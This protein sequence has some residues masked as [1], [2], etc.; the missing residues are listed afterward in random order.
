MRPRSHEWTHVRS[1]LVGK[2]PFG[3]LCSS[4][5]VERALN[6]L[7]CTHSRIYR[8]LWPLSKLSSAALTDSFW[9]VWVRPM[10]GK[11]IYKEFIRKIPFPCRI[12][13]RHSALTGAKGVPPMATSNT[14]PWSS[15]TTMG[16]IL[17]SCFIL[18]MSYYRLAPRYPSVKQS[19]WILTTFSS[20]IMTL[21]STPFLYD[22][23]SNGG[24][25]KYIR[26]IPNLSITVS[27]FFQSYLAMWV[28]TFYL[29]KSS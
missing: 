10:S 19:A 25:V 20:A 21:A 17:F 26:I 9:H 6:G 4:S 11:R 5:T 27:R 3:F 8:V 28:S 24:S 14:P 7:V 23:F 15:T 1:L 2:R 12:L 16:S 29:T 13:C 22:Y 18:A